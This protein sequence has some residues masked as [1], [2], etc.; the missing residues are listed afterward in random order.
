V[1]VGRRGQRVEDVGHE[2]WGGSLPIDERRL[3]G[4]GLNLAGARGVCHA[5]A[6][7]QTEERRRS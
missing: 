1:G 5:R 2:Q 3:A 6:A 7:G 4:R